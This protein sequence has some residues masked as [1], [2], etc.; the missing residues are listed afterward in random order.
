M[1]CIKL[2]ILLFLIERSLCQVSYSSI[3]KTLSTE[4]KLNLS[5][6]CQEDFML[7]VTSPQI[8]LLSKKIFV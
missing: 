7:A 6:K 4:I 1:R 5:E 3:V 8:I 2:F